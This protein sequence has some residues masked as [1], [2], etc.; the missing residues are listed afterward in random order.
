MVLVVDYLVLLKLNKQLNGGEKVMKEAGFDKVW[1][2][3]I[4]VPHWVRGEKEEAYFTINNKKYNVPI[5][6]LGGSIPTPENGIEAE[7][8]EVK[9]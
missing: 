2:Q 9:V 3:P 4:M 8:I 5:C 1:L 7:V 6:A